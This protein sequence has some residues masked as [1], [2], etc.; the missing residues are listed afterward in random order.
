LAA[1][2]VLGASEPED[3]ARVRWSDRTVA[4]VMLSFCIYRC[5]SIEY[6][7]PLLEAPQQPFKKIR[8]I[9]ALTPLRTCVLRYLPRLR[10]QFR[11]RWIFLSSLTRGSLDAQLLNLTTI[12]FELVFTLLTRHYQLRWRRSLRMQSQLQVLASVP[13][14]T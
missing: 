1:A 9:T 13:S 6:L 2:P 12:A 10:C 14:K 7:H 3:P 11:V 4:S 5:S 8:I